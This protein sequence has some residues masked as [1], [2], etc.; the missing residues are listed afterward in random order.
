MFLLC[1]LIC[2]CFLWIFVCSFLLDLLCDIFVCLS[3]PIEDMTTP[4]IVPD[5]KPFVFFRTYRQLSIFFWWLYHCHR[6]RFFFLPETVMKRS[7]TLE[8]HSLTART[9]MG[10]GKCFL[11]RKKGVTGGAK[12]CPLVAELGCDRF[13]LHC[14]ATGSSSG[15]I[16]W[17]KCIGSRNMLLVSLCD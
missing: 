1:F 7:W 13:Y 17:G 8:I 9:A 10:S 12:Q 15:G 5:A 3:D 16:R 4:G 6:P 2:F 14:R 11:T